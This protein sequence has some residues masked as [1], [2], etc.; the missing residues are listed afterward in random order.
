M[1]LDGRVYIGLAWYWLP[2]LAYAGTI[3]YLSSLSAPEDHFE[4]LANAFISVPVAIFSRI[5]DKICH[6]AEYAILGILTYRAIRYSWGTKLGPSVGLIT[7]IAVTVFGCTDEFHQWFTPLRQVEGWDI[8]AD[9]LGGLFG[10]SL[11]KWG[12]A[13]PT[14][15]LLE[16]HLPL[17][18]QLSRSLATSKF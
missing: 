16:E 8:M 5:N 12:N 13:I 4:A 3:A 1:N 14:M 18:L 15:K 17:K 2:L 6:I 10:V 9:A 11:W 7:V